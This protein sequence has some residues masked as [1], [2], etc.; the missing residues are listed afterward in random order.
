MPLF[1]QRTAKF[2]NENAKDISASG[3]S[4]YACQEDG[5]LYAW[6]AA[7]SDGR[8]AIDGATRNVTIP[9]EVFHTIEIASLHSGLS[10]SGFLTN[11]SELYLWGTLYSYMTAFDEAGSAQAALVD[12]ALLSYGHEPI[13]LY[14]N[15]KSVAF[16]DA[17]I[18]LLL[19]SGEV[20]TWGSNDHGQ[21]GNGKYTQTA[22]TEAED[23]EGYEVE[24]ISSADSVFPNVPIT[25]K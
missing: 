12:G 24:I 20:Y 6:G 13:R 19:E 1:S 3:E 23:D 8:L 11:Q 15:V 25:L 18:A 16:G 21:L 7:A 2:T 10:L 4:R 22:L 14:E 5:A 17:F 9:E